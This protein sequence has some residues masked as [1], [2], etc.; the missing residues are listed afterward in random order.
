MRI[1]AV[2]VLLLPWV[3]SAA[4]LE[5]RVVEDHSGRALPSVELRVARAGVR[6][7]VAD[8]ETGGDG[9]FRADAVPDGDYAIEVLKPNF[10]SATLRVRLGPE[11][12][13]LFVRLARFGVI[14]GRVADA[15]GRAVPGVNITAMTRRAG[16]AM[17]PFGFSIRL[18]ESGQYRV[19]NLPP[20]EYAVAA[21][22]GAASAAGASGGS[23]LRS[24]V[25]SGVLF[26][27]NNQR[28]QWFTVA[29]G[30]EYAN[31]DFIIGTP[32]L[33]RV[34]GT[35][36]PAGARYAVALTALD[37]PIIPVATQ[38]LQSDSGT[39]ELEGIPPGSYELYASGPVRGYGANMVFL[40][41]EPVFGSIRVNV[42]G[43]DVKGLAVP[44]EKGRSASFILRSASPQQPAP[45]GCPATAGLKLARIEA[46]GAN[47]DRTVEVNFTKPQK[48][49]DLA[50]GH[51]RLT[52]DRLGDS[53]YASGGVVDLTAPT[54]EPI[55]VAVASAASLRGRLTA[56]SGR[57]GDYVVIL[58]ATDA[59]EG[60]QPVQAV[61]PDAGFRFVVTGLRPGRYRIG[62]QPAAGATRA[63]WAAD[64][65]RM[66]EID[67][68]GG[69]PTDID[70]PAPAAARP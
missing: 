39:F 60:T 34:S 33:F 68:P 35:V 45:A 10:V 43:E 21:S 41:P 30:E 38:R 2:V 23:G 47:P 36:Q 17:Q 6:Q 7:L 52:V 46:T 11:S 70:L 48:L 37:Q 26:Y 59:T 65:A 27:P 13:P 44:V 20:G 22:Y 53:C 32:A 5:G 67:L 66:I 25:G 69:A 3:A 12:A 31:T 54:E 50:P 62:A 57:P 42:G 49:D 18:D 63:R 28:P 64:L 15:D 16:G 29:G 61:Y 1:A 9:R 56:A 40:G 19:F 8:L 58:V 51:Y 14:S 24:T 4:T 55:A